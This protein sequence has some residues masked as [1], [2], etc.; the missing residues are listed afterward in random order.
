MKTYGVEN[1]PAKGGV[2]IASNHVAGGDPPF[3]GG[4]IKRESYFLAKKELFRNFFLR[5]LIE[6][7]NAIPVD[8]S[9]LDQRAIEAAERALRNGKAL[10]LFPEGTRS[11][12]GEIGKG[13]PGIGLLARR[14]VVPIVPAYIQ[15]S[16]A[17][18]K[19]PFTGRRLIISYGCPIDSAWI[20]SVPDSKEGYRQIAE[21]VMTHIRALG[22]ARGQAAEPGP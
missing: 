7:L 4:G 5:T 18:L 16:G 12:T 13:K 19:L 20:A 10:I 21:E 6:S 11:K 8:R 14:A 17:F 2:I 1:V 3:I 22:Q 15:N 9:V